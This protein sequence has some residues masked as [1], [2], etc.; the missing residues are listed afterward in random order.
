[1][2]DRLR[3]PLTMESTLRDVAA[4][5]HARPG[6]PEFHRTPDRH[7]Y[8]E[9]R[10]VMLPSNVGSFCILRAFIPH[11][12]R[13]CVGFGKSPI[14]AL[15]DCLNKRLLQQT[16]LR[17]CAHEPRRPSCDPSVVEG[18]CRACGRVETN[19]LRWSTPGARSATTGGA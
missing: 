6:V 8:P 15:I 16:S 9:V 11:G 18:H 13:T 17:E 14:G 5:L 3:E 10:G 4:V 19:D 1:M 2:T 7:A 12:A